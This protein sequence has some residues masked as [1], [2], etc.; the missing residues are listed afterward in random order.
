LGLG[1]VKRDFYNTSTL[2]F[3]G[4]PNLQKAVNEHLAYDSL[5][6]QQTELGYEISYAPPWFV[7]AVIKMDY[8]VLFLRANTLHHEFIQVTVN[9]TNGQTAWINRFE[10]TLIHWPEFL[11]SVNKIESL[12]PENNPL[13][14]KPLR[15]ASL[16]NTQ[17]TFLRT[18]QVK[19]Q[20]I[21]VELLDDALQVLDTG[22]LR[23]HEQGRLVV[24]WSLFS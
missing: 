10:A 3:C 6:F 15:H 9:E 23:W 12:D 21:Q 4:N 1:L 17:S 5:V 11:I 2:F 18:M 24:R 20:W 19:A 22:W 7:P 14:I 8:D 16:V 13:R